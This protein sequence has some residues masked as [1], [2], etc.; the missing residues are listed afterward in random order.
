MNAMENKNPLSS[1]NLLLLDIVLF[2]QDSWRVIA[3]TGALGVIFS[4]IFLFAT[5][6]QYEASSIADMVRVQDPK[7]PLGMNVEEP[8]ALIARM[9]LFSSYDQPLRGACGLEDFSNFKTQLART[10]KFSIPKGIN[11][12]VE[13]K[14]T[15]SSPEIVKVCVGNLIDAISRS[16]LELRDKVINR[17]RSNLKTIEGR[18]MQ[19]KALLRRV[20][21]ENAAIT[22]VYVQLLLDI[23]ELEDEYQKSLGYVEGLKI[24]KP[25]S[26]EKIFVGLAKPRAALTLSIGLM[27]GVF[28][29]FFIALIHR[30]LLKIKKSQH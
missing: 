2:L 3:I 1:E 16:Q 18:L 25:Q 27:A 19:D 22:P 8:T 23:R 30:E 10:I 6:V 11:S 28:F 20:Q 12:A 14:A 13:I 21:Q 4:G 7:N 29:G 5:P 9:G 15:G 24:D 17:Y 26:Q